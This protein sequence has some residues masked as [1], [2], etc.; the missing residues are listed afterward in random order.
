[1]ATSTPVYVQHNVEF[2]VDSLKL[3]DWRDM[4]IDFSTGMYRTAIKTSYFSDDSEG[5]I[6]SEK[7]WSTIIKFADLSIATKSFLISIKS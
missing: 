3:A 6:S 7:R 5:G 1:M 4:K 2:F